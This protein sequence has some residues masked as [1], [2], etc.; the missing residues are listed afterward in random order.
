MG[1]SIVT[2]LTSKNNPL[3]EYTSQAPTST[4]YSN[5]LVDAG[6]VSPQMARVLTPQ[7]EPVKKST[8]RI[9]TKA[10]V[11]T[12]DEVTVEIGQ[13]DRKSREETERKEK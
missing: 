7:D 4:K 11:L 10:R 5:P 9:V 13:K 8:R 2:P 3:P 1:Q 12:S 6:L